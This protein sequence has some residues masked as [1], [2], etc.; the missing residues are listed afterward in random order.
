MS[1]MTLDSMF[2]PARTVAPAPTR[3][4]RGVERR[5]EVRLTRR[6][7]LVVL[8]LALLLVLGVGLLVAAGSVATGEAGE[9]VPTRVVLVSSGDTLWDIAASLAADGEVREVMEQIKRL[10]ALESGS[11]SAGQ[12]ILVPAGG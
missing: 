12:R 11:L 1:T 8:V 3:P 6:G 9:P 5:S 4:A 10:N 7:R 2:G